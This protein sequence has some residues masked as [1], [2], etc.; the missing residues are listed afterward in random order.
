MF[1][2]YLHNME[3]TWLFF[4]LHFTNL[5]NKLLL[6]VIYHQLEITLGIFSAVDRGWT[7]FDLGGN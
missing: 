1:T 5:G 4:L 2:E 6:L 3:V 7:L